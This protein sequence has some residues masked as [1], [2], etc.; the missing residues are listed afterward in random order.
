VIRIVIGI[1]LSLFLFCSPLEASAGVV[2]TAESIHVVGRLVMNLTPE[3]EN[4]F[5]TRT[6]GL[7]KITRDKDP[8][9][10]YSCNRDIEH[11]GTYVFDEIWPSQQSLEDH[12]NTPH[13]FAW[14][15]WVKPH[16]ANDL[17]VEVASTEAFHTL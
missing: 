16:L 11:P 6:L 10:S 5:E 13:F 4:E 14:W 3:Q 2:T 15:D 8:V 9:T 12:L 17:D 7:A 1:A